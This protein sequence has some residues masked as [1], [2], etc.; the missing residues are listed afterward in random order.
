MPDQG[1]DQGWNVVKSIPDATAPAKPSAEAADGWNV[2]ASQPDE[3]AAQTAQT[4]QTYAAPPVAPPPAFVPQGPELG[5]PHPQTGNGLPSPA[6]V[7]AATTQHAQTIATALNAPAP[8]PTA[9]TFQN[10]RTGRISVRQPPGQERGPLSMLDMP[11]TGGKEIGAGVQQVQQPGWDA[12][13]G[14]VS[15]VLRGAFEA[16][17]P[18]MLPSM[19]ATPLATAGA[20]AAGAVSQQAVEAGLT[21]LGLPP[22]W[23]ALAGDLAG[24]IGGIAGHKIST[25][26]AAALKAK[27]EPIL[28]ARAEKANAPTAPPETAT[29]NST[30]T[31]PYQ[32]GSTPPP[33]PDAPPIEYNSTGTPTYR[34][35]ATPPP[36]APVPSKLGTPPTPP[37]VAPT[38][39]SVAK[40][41]QSAKPKPNVKKGPMTITQPAAPPPPTLGPEPAP[42]GWNVVKSEPTPTPA[43]EKPP[44]T[45]E[46]PT[47]PASIVAHAEPA[48]P[49]APPAKPAAPGWENHAAPDWWGKAHG[50]ESIAQPW[51]TVRDA[52][53]ARARKDPHFKQTMMDYAHDWANAKAEAGVDRAI[54]AKPEA[55]VQAAKP[56][57]TAAATAEKPAVV[58]VKKIAAARKEGA[59]YTEAVAKVDAEAKAPATILDAVNRLEPT[60]GVPVS[61]LRLRAEFPN[62]SK[63]QFD[64]QALELRKQQK[65][66]LSQHGDPQNLNQADRDML[67][68]DPARNEYFTAVSERT[69]EPA[70]PEPPNNRVAAR[71]AK[72]DA[73]LAKL[74]AQY[75]KRMNQPDG[76]RPPAIKAD[77][78]ASIAKLMDKLETERKALAPAGT[79]PWQPQREIDRMAAEAAKPGVPDGINP[80]T[81]KPWSKTPEPAAPT[82]TEELSA[83]QAKYSGPGPHMLNAES[84][85]EPADATRIDELKTQLGKQPWQ[86]RQQAAREAEGIRPEVHRRIVEKALAEG[87]PIPAEVLADYPDLAKPTTVAAPAK[88]VESSHGSSV[89]NPEVRPQPEQPAS[90]GSPVS[91]PRR[92]S[93]P[94]TYGAETEVYAEGRDEPYKARYAVRELSDTYPSHNPFTFEPNPDFRYINDRDYSLPA[95]RQRVVTASGSKFRPIKVI[96]TNPDAINGPS[97]IERDGNVLGGNNRRMALERA[98]SMNPKG[99]AAYRA[100]LIRDAAH[101]GLDPAAIERMKQPILVRE[102][103]ESELD[104]QHA[105][106]EFNYSPAGGHSIGERAAADARGMTPETGKYLAAVMEGAGPEATL[107]DVLNGKRGP[108]VVNHLIQAGIF[109]EGERPE[110]LDAVTDAVT[111]EAKQRIAKM[112][113]G[114]LF[115]NSEEFQ[116]AEPSLR[117]KL[118][119]IVGILKQLESSG[120]DWNLTPDVKQAIEGFSFERDYGKAYGLKPGESFLIK[121]P[122]SALQGQREYQAGMFG[123]APKPPELSPRA[124]ALGE[125]IRTNNQTA[126]ARAFRAFAEKSTEK[127]L[128]GEADPD[129]AFQSAFGSA[130]PRRGSA[131]LNQMTLGLANPVAKFVAD[132]IAP[133]LKDIAAGLAEIPSGLLKIFWPTVLDRF[134]QTANLVMRRHIGEK[135]RRLVQ[136]EESLREARK[137]FNRQPAEDNFDFIDRMEDQTAGKYGR[138]QK[139]A[140]LDEIA[141]VLRELLDGRRAMV[142]ALGTG[143]LRSFYE[144]YFPRIWAKPERAKAVFSQFFSKRPLEGSK[145][146]LKKRTYPTLADGRAAGLVPLTDNP[147]D[148][149]LAKIAEQDTYITGHRIIKDPAMMRRFVDA[150]DGEVPFGY[151]KLNDP[152]GVVYGQSVQQ[153][154]EF[155]N[156]G[157]Y[158]GLMKAA[159]AL[160]ITTE[161]GFLKGMGQAIGKAQRTGAIVK[162]L[163]GTKEGTLAHEI[164]H[165]IDWL[166]GSSKRFVL[167]Y[168]DAATVARLKAAYATI[169]DKTAAP[170]ARTAA[171]AELKALKG[172][173]ADRKEFQKQLRD[174]ADLRNGRKDYV[175]KREEKMAQLAQMWVEGRDL[176]K[177]TA[178]KVFAEWKKFLNENPKLHALRD[179]EASA[180][181]TIISQPYDVGGLVIKGHWYFPEN[182]T[183]LLDNYLSGSLNR[184]ALFR[185]GMALNSSMNLFNLGLSMFHVFKVG[186]EASASMGGI[187]VEQIVRGNPLG[188]A[189]SIAKGVPAPFTNFLRGIPYLKEYLRP[190]TQG[191]EIGRIVD[192]LSGG[193]ARIAM[194]RLYQ[195][196][197]AENMAKA[198]HRG[199]ILGAAVRLPFAAMEL[200]TRIIMNKIVPAMKWGTM[201]E[202]LKADLARLGPEAKERDIMRVAAETVN[203][204]DNRM[205]EVA[206]DNFFTHRFVKDI[207]MFLMRADQFTLGTVRLFGGAA[208]DIVRQPLNAYRGEPVNLK[209][210]S[211]VAGMLMFHMAYSALYQRLHTGQWPQEGEDYFYPKN[212]QTDE[213]GRPQRTS[214][215]SYLKDVHSFARHPLQTAQNKV[216]PA[217]ELFSELLR[218]EDFWHVEIQHPDD[219]IAARALQT[220]KF[221]AKA[222]EPRSIENATR[223]SKLGA[224]P[225]DLAEQFFGLSPAARDLEASP[226]ERMAREY[227]AARTPD[228]P[229]TAAS[230]ERRDLRQSLAR[231]LRQKKPIPAD[232]LA[233]R[234]AGTLTRRDMSEAVRES[235]GSSL[236]NSFT[237]LGIEEALRVFR[238]ATPAEK[239]T[240]RAALKKK[241]LAAMANMGPEQR[242]K[243]RAALIESLR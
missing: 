101:F 196:S 164:G 104:P 41:P 217:I 65:V 161:R 59:T 146:F 72:I 16:A 205:G 47:P 240:L 239:T 188:G 42:P 131:T 224:S 89:S 43:V 216:A 32:P 194:D 209:R 184:Y 29:A 212:G 27:Y 127:S 213:N 137:Y 55:P 34:P 71:I 107:T 56:A 97:I 61:T 183:R 66:F 142:Q 2:V 85:M 118:E 215:W 76:M 150:R 87:K 84:G 225:G 120:A 235:R 220:G 153:I 11:I 191:A 68:H 226:A 63:E 5:I 166:A 195:T 108:D 139:N 178:P 73:Q 200:P 109:T 219:P 237:H 40:T 36:P 233:A 202:M 26:A 187:G 75:V 123:A 67:I 95:N 48:K 111:S 30:G 197:I 112:L 199:N 90:Q 147:V 174:L 93:H 221:I 3:P 124:R 86:R 236:V 192:I 21:K 83:L 151:R 231:A 49:E 114:G 78:L 99:V 17:T 223:E 106:T 74:D 152:I 13:A 8:P 179:T 238:A 128:F 9:P 46:K 98:Y 157:T 163:H 204:V 171:Y 135:E 51:E 229:R 38:V 18:F 211:Y 60:R 134:S 31:E 159:D 214:L 228:E 88:P 167:E 132:D 64:K 126:I 7:D 4:A 19:A 208:V 173:I 218:N 28:K 82:P 130:D 10:P 185:G 145:S 129:E 181:G 182:A 69:D 154:A 156:E 12:K 138:P 110:L 23:S 175:R 91:E 125:F 58:R 158:E 198:F 115:K 121:A 105:I 77:A 122:E 227:A 232:V 193:G 133:K 149:A 6:D 206:R 62:L 39:Q 92:P 234:K 102:L 20:L 94:G 201:G 35:G 1:V 119:R 241:G 172:A 14:G 54:P 15:K 162:T 169:K 22:G 207:S 80:R 52:Y 79:P 189:L 70:A 117:N 103:D 160:G 144:N 113:L 170:A 45:V 148:F 116:A 141:R 33:P 44:A 230:A 143:K 177:R 140:Y 24:L 180:N 100:L 136:A 57:Q 186:Y 155:P 168:P 222:F 203:E 210:L 190:G 25:P 81:G 176:F 53:V 37:P 96:N 243:T 50:S 242:A 165:Q